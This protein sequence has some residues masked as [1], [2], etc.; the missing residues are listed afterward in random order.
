MDNTPSHLNLPERIHWTEEQGDCMR[1]LNS[2]D[3]MG[4]LSFLELKEPIKTFNLALPVTVCITRPP[5]KPVFTEE[6]ISYVPDLD[7]SCNCGKAYKE[8]AYW[9]VELEK[10]NKL[11]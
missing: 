1:E 11:K 10:Q 5:L 9:K 2:Y 7:A 6:T 3:T 4:I 8:H